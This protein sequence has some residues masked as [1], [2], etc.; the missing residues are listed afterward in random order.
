CYN[1]CMQ[2]IIHHGT[3]GSRDGNWF[4]WLDAELTKLGQNVVRPQLPVDDF[5]EVETSLKN[6]GT[7]Q[8]P[9]QTK[10]SWLSTFKE[11]VLPQLIGEPLVVVAH[12]SA[13]A[14]TLSSVT[15]FDL[16]LDSAIFVSPFIED[17]GNKTFDIINND[18]YKDEF[19]FA[20]IKN[21]I[22][23]SYTLYSDTDPY[24]PMSAGQS[25]ARHLESHEILVKSAGH[26]G[27][28]FTEFPVVLELCKTRIGF[29]E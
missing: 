25:F 28:A 4:P 17:L 15:E 27:S 11:T 1:I 23:H 9:K 26:M 13:P 7:Y 16:K 21:N 10:T 29:G 2:F 6:S 8:N 22:P 19:D 20:K 3:F 18:F 14:F 24:V 12:S 5:A